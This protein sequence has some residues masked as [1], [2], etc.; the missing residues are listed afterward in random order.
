[1]IIS[2]AVVIRKIHAKSKNNFAYILM[3]L[4]LVVGVAQIGLAIGKS[5]RKKVVLADK[6][7][8]FSNQYSLDTFK[9]LY[10]ISSAL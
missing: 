9:Y 5:F 1:M 10:T 3:G 8:Y 2:A 6:T 7:H 4:T